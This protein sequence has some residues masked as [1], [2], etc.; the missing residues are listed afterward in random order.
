MDKNI[1]G[2]IKTRLIDKGVKVLLGSKII[3]RITDEIFL[4]DRSVIK[5]KNF[6]WIGGIRIS[7]LIKR[8]GLK[9]SMVGKLI[10]DEYLKSEGNKYVYA[11]SDS[12]NAINPV[13]NIPVPAAAQFAL[14]QG[15]LAAENIYAE[16]FGRPKKDY[17]PKVLGEVVSLGKHLAI[18]W[19]ALPIIKKVTFV[20]FLVRL[21]RSALR[22]KHIFLLRKE[23]RN[24][25]TY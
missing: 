6:I 5:S 2:K 18:G 9:T 4:S 1:S 12:A 11:I 13:T 24:W 7:D 14:Q 8:G 15:R 23:S 25:I 16:I 10:V 3:K 17:Y 20:G 21:L 19:L 22:E